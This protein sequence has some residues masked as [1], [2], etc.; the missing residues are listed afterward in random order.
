MH[1]TR[2]AVWFSKTRLLKDDA[3]P[4]AVLFSGPHFWFLLFRLNFFS[5]LVENSRSLLIAMLQCMSHHYI[6]HTGTN[7]CG[8][9]NLNLVCMLLYYAKLV[10][11]SISNYCDNINSNLVCTLLYYAKLVRIST[12]IYLCWLVIHDYTKWFTILFEAPKLMGI[13]G[14]CS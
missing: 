4:L 3:S 14:C 5:V 12:S 2:L 7:Y 8:N 11:I 9:I 1:P 13:W 6:C 10:R